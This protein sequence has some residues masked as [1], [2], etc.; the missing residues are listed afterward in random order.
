MVKTVSDIL[1]ERGKRYG[2]FYDHADITQRL[3]EVM[4]TTRDWDDLPPDVKEALEMIQ[5]KVA[6]ILNGQWQ[7]KDSWDDTAG[8][9]TLVS[10]RIARDYPEDLFS[11]QAV[12]EELTA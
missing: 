2:P 9:A 3:K 4:H 10:K 5:H 11:L 7:Y 1:E 8:Y 12:V 6:R